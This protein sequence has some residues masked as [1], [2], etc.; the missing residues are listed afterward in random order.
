MG[1]SVILKGEDI[2]DSELKSTRAL[3]KNAN[4]EEE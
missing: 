4:Q 2:N 3:N 1:G